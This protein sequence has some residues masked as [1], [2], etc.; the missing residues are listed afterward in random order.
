M[1][2]KQLN[3][4]F[5]ISVEA[6]A[7]ALAHS[8]SGIQIQALGSE[9]EPFEPAEK[10]KLLAPPDSLINVVLRHF[11]EHPNE[12]VPHEDIKFIAIQR[13]RS[14]KTCDSALYNLKSRGL[15]RRS[16]GRGRYRLTAKGRNHG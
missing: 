2:V 4:T 9:P 16:G 5:N 11:K 10:P 13:G 15:I 12:V 6:L 3:V 8:N 7:Q 1:P 14:Q